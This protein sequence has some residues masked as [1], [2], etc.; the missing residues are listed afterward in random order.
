MSSSLIVHVVDDD[1]R[2]RHAVQRLLIRQGIGVRLY[3]SAT[4]FLDEYDEQPGCLLLDLSMPGMTGLE[5]LEVVRSRQLDV[6]VL[7]LTGHGSID[8]AVQ[9]M[10]S[11]AEDFLQ[12]PFD[13]ALLLSKV[14]GALRQSQEVVARRALSEDYRQRLAILTS[15]EREVMELIVTGLTSGE[16]ASELAI[17]KKTVDIHRGRV[18]AKM[19]AASTTELVRDWM[20]RH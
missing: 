16:I 2:I 3:E 19:E 17:S 13:N 9:A 6:V 7:V 5:L 18:M 10:R 8:R 20:S 15:R 11:G 4:A 12:K 1:E 14:Q